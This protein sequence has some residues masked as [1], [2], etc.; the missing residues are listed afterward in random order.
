MYIRALLRGFVIYTSICSSL[1]EL[2]S[3]IAKPLLSNCFQSISDLY[4]AEKD[5]VMGKE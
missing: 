2:W 1:Y 4:Q 5:A 3:G